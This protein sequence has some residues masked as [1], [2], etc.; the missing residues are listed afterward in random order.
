MLD[1]EIAENK[2]SWRDRA[3]LVIV[4]D[5]D[6]CVV[7][8]DDVSPFVT[9]QVRDKTRVL[10]DLPPLSGPE[11]VDREINRAEGAVPFVQRGVYSSTAATRR[12]SSLQ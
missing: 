4:R 3:V 10:V 8:S 7:E 5:A 6:S 12:P 11:V 9:G 2:L 1:A